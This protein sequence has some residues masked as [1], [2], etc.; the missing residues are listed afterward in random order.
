MKI[1]EKG[2]DEFEVTVRVGK[3][4]RPTQEHFID[5]IEIMVGESTYRHVINPGEPHEA[6]FI[7][8]IETDPVTDTCY[9]LVK[10]IRR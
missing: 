9:C 1:V 3:T 10:G 7:F 5:W 4:A 2:A 6:T 8:T